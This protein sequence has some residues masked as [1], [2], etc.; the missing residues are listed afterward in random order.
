MN[1]PN[2]DPHEIN[3]FS[4]MA[5]NWWDPKGDLKTLHHINPVRLEYIENRSGELKPKTVADI[6]CGGGI[7]AESMDSKGAI[8]TAIDASEE[9]L[10][11]ARLQQMESGSKVHYL[12]STAE[13]LAA[14]N[15]E[16]F[17]VVTC[18]EL[19][20]HVPSPESII[21][22]C[23]KLVKTDGYIFLSTLNRTLKAYVFAVLGAE[24]VLSLLPKG[25]HD[26]AKFIQPA[27][28]A[29]W[30][31]KHDLN[32]EDLSGMSYN[33]INSEAALTEDLKVNY[34][35]CAQKQ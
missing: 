12:H 25:T 15:Y 16:Q 32:L 20:E 21:V 29:N 23:K 34:L 1:N 6:G 3:K 14:D 10:Q 13:A 5:S 4:L 27:E 18:M 17:D 33:P 8:V 2:I 22:A 19:L 11:V 28:I 26:Y 35:I 7:L 30:L 9:A 31:R 24:Y